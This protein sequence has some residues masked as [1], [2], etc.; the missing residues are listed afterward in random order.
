MICF[1]HNDIHDG[2]RRIA[3]AV[4][5]DWG[6]DDERDAVNKTYTFCSFACIADWAVLRS[7]DWDGV[8][9][10]SPPESHEEFSP[11]VDETTDT[12]IRG[13]PA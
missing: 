7:H 11:I 13:E 9:V 12:I 10:I 5:V 4:A 3:L 1:C 8:T 6:T 2:D